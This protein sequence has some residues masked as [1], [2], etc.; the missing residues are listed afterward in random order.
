[1]KLRIIDLGIREPSFIPTEVQMT[2]HIDLDEP[3]ILYYITNR[4]FLLVPGTRDYTKDIFIDKIPDGIGFIR[5]YEESDSDTRGVIYGGPRVLHFGLKLREGTLGDIDSIR[6]NL[7]ISLIKILKS[8]DIITSNNPLYN[9]HNDT[10]V[11]HDGRYKKIS[12][13]DWFS[14]NGWDGIYML[15]A[16]KFNYNL[17]NNI[18][19]LQSQKM[20]KKKYVTNIKDVILGL[21]EIKNNLEPNKIGLELAKQFCDDIGIDYYVG[22]FSKRELDYINYTEPI[23]NKTKWIVK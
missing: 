7:Q 20:N 11:L 5:G 18:Y 3:T 2:N 14:K 9:K 1:M 15:I 13:V 22:E 8:L 12:G 6:T 17:L 21:D 23:M 10:M 16:F 4:E 19:N